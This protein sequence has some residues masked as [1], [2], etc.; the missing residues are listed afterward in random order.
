MHR[1]A[2]RNIDVLPRRQKQKTEGPLS[3][4]GGL[5]RHDTTHSVRVE[6]AK[7]V[8]VPKKNVDGNF[9]GSAQPSQSQYLIPP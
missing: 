7:R 1:F 3:R 9:V 2:P 5:F 8:H 6:R 4:H